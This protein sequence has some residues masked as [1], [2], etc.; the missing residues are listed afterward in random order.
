MGCSI[1]ALR[2]MARQVLEPQ[3][4]RVLYGFYENEHGNAYR[5]LRSGLTGNEALNV[6]GRAAPLQQFSNENR[7]SSI[8]KRVVLY[9]W[10]RLGERFGD[11]TELGDAHLIYQVQFFQKMMGAGIDGIIYGLD[12]YPYG[13]SAT[14][15]L[16]QIRS[17]L[18][19]NGGYKYADI[20]DNP[21]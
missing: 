5:L 21:W 16:V 14:Q 10:M 6:D 3:G 12:K 2:D 1:A 15:T 7:P 17:S 4:V 8:Q 18:A 13:G 19:Q 9:G 11:C 20:N